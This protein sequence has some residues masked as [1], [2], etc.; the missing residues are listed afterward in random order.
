MADVQD[1]I[2][3]VVKK[4]PTAAV[5]LVVLILTIGY[6]LTS[7]NLNTPLIKMLEASTTAANKQATSVDKLAESVQ[8]LTQVVADSNK[9][10]DTLEGKTTQEIKFLDRR[11]TFIEDK[12]VHNQAPEPK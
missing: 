1:T 2:Q 12:L 8:A 11:V 4:V 9:R 3:S 7:T 6:F 10:I 5:T